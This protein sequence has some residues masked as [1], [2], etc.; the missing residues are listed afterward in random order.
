MRV[1]GEVVEALAA[2]DVARIADEAVRLRERAGPMK[3]GSASIERQDETQAPHWMQAI[4]CV[5]STIDSGGTTR[6]RS[7]GSPSSSSTG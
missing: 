4:V 2:L 1:L 5:M 6:S 7:G 3:S